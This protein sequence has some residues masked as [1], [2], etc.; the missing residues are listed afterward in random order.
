LVLRLNNEDSTYVI[1]YAVSGNWTHDVCC[2]S[3]LSDI[4][5]LRLQRIKWYIYIT[6]TAY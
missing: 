5:I 2:I 3:V 6:I 1:S 4:Y